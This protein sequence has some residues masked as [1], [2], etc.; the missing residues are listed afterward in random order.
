M[1][2]PIKYDKYRLIF[3]ADSLGEKMEQFIS[4]FCE[5]IEIHIDRISEDTLL[6]EIEKWDS[7]A[8]VVFGTAVRENYGKQL[9]RADFMK[10]KTVADLYH[11]AIS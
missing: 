3:H 2:Q 6:D 11:I 10:A 7:L 1:S 4:L 5:T 8:R 9:T